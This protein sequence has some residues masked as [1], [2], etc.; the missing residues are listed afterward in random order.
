MVGVNED[1]EG[2]LFNRNCHYIATA[3][4]HAFGEGLENS[5]HISVHRGSYM[6]AHVALNLLKEFGKKR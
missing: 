6:N 1:T 3:F 4:I 2:G 5:I